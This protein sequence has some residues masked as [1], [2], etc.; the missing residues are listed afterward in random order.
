MG[1]RLLLQRGRDA[2]AQVAGECAA[3]C[4]Y[5]PLDALLEA[6][7]YVLYLYLRYNYNYGLT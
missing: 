5:A 7:V 4:E 1:R 2:P 6:L 3:A